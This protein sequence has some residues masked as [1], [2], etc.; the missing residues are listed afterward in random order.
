MSHFCMSCFF[1][2]IRCMITFLQAKCPSGHIPIDSSHLKISQKFPAYFNYGEFEY[3]TSNE[4]SSQPVNIRWHWSGC[5]CC[6][7]QALIRFL[8][9]KQASLRPEFKNLQTT[10]NLKPLYAEMQK[11]K[12]LSM[13]AT[14]SNNSS[15]TFF[16][17][18][19]QDMRLKKCFNGVHW[20]CMLF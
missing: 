19:A 3:V 18:L 12:F 20:Y 1:P 7:F 13:C 5:V 15:L 11:T 16:F 4:N 17:L 6:V 14:C 2:W 9:S 8:P 10:I